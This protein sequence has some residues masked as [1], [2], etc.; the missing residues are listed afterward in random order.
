[1]KQNFQPFHTLFYHVVRLLQSSSRNY[2]DCTFIWGLG[3]LWVILSLNISKNDE[4]ITHPPN[5]ILQFDCQLPAPSSLQANRTSDT[6]V[7]LSWNAVQNANSYLITVLDDTGTNIIQTVS[8][9]GTTTN[10]GGLLTGQ[11]YVFTVAAKCS[12]T[13][14]SSFIIWYDIL[15]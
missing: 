6:Q 10:L 15:D 2:R 1:M 12:S 13:D 9:S 8:V 7:Y 14:V 5:T 3:L 11:R 4:L